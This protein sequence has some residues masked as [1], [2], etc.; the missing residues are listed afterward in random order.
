MM[1]YFVWWISQALYIFSV[2][3]FEKT[4]YPTGFLAEASAKLTV[5]N[6]ANGKDFWNNAVEFTGPSF[7]NFAFKAQGNFQYMFVFHLFAL[8]WNMTFLIYLTYTVTAGAIANW[9]FT[10]RDDKGNKKRGEGRDELS[11]SPVWAA[12]KRTFFW[13]TGTIA[14]A[15]A[16][17]GMCELI[18][19]T[20]VYLADKAKGEN[21]GCCRKCILG[22]ITCCMHCVTCCLEKV[23]KQAIV[24]TAIWGDSFIVSCCSSFK[25]IWDNLDRVA[26]ITVVSGFL[27]LLGKALVSLLVAGIGGLVIQGIYGEEVS[28]II[29]PCVI[30][31]VLS[32]V[33]ATLFMSIFEVTLDCI[34]ICFLVDEYNY[35]GTDEMYASKSLADVIKNF[36]SHSEKRAMK[37]RNAAAL[38]AGGTG[39]A[40]ATGTA[41][42]TTTT[43]GT[44]AKA[45]DTTTPAAEPAK[46][47]V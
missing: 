7:Q 34:F 38:R 1:L 15:S 14:F 36:Q 33:V 2:A 45:A 21:P 11:T 17:V 41:A 39:A 18:R 26:A 5:F 35:G 19:T 3:E 40:A 31:F 12:I 25:L 29:M 44:E 46:A 23:S 22:P 6:T 32:F 43:A 30:I 9:Y 27:M 8:L 20:V 13:H 42:A 47:A 37:I 4:D 28:S 16:I 24:W 10:R